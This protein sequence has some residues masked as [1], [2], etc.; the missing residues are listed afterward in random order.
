MKRNAAPRIPTRWGDGLFTKP[1]KFQC[2]DV[3][4]YREW[5]EKKYQYR[6]T[7]RTVVKNVP[8]I[9]LPDATE[10][11]WGAAPGICHPPT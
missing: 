7:K 6:A 9:P 10:I 8:T 5:E 1:S 4:P 3:C 11:T 2:G